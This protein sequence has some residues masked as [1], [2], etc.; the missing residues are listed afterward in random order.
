MSEMLSENQIEQFILSGFLRID[1]AFSPAVA[2]AALN[3]LWND[4]PCDR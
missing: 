3:I 4:L 2:D 1:Q